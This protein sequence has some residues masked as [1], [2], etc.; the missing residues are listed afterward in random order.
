MVRS[1]V[2]KSLASWSCNVHTAAKDGRKYL[3]VDDRILHDRFDI[4]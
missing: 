3:P 4:M 1:P 2:K